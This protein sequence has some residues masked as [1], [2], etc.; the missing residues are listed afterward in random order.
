MVLA[1][2]QCLSQLQ[3]THAWPNET[4]RRKIDHEDHDQIRG[5]FYRGDV[6]ADQAS[7]VS[8]SLCNGMVSEREELDRDATEE[9]AI[10]P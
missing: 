5:C 7:S 9:T 1:I 2:T 6:Y 10:G 3:I 8:V 4:L